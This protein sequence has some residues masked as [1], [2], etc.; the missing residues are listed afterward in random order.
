MCD[1]SVG[2][3]NLGYYFDIPYNI[4]KVLDKI[5]ENLM[6]F[7]Y[8]PSQVIISIYAKREYKKSN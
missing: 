7:F 2:L 5:S 1:L 4:D 6:W 8:L 3:Y